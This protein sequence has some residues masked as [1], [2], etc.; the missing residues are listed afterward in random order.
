MVL[1]YLLEGLKREQKGKFAGAIPSTITE[2][3]FIW[4]TSEVADER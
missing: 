1:C 3:A 4:I 2:F